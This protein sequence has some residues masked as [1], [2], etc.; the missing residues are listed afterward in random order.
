MKAVESTKVDTGSCEA[1]VGVVIH[2]GRMYLRVSADD[3]SVDIPF[4]NGDAER[5]RRRVEHLV[6]Y[7]Y[8]D[9]VGCYYGLAGERAPHSGERAPTA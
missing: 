6:P 5:F 3:R 7:N 9:V 8:G 4:H 2:E 1:G